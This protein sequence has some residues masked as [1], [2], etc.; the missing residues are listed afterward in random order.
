MKAIFL[1]TIISIVIAS[2]FAFARQPFIGTIQMQ[3]IPLDVPN[4]DIKFYRFLDKNG[5]PNHGKPDLLP[6][7]LF[8]NTHE[9]EAMVA[10]KMALGHDVYAGNFRGH[11]DGKEK[12]TVINYQEGDYSFLKMAEE[13]FPAMLKKVREISGQKVTIIGHSMGGMVPRA[14]IALGTVDQNDIE[15]MVLIGSPP[16]FR[17][18]NSF[19]PSVIEEPLMKMILAGSGKDPFSIMDIFELERRLDMVNVANPVYWIAKFGIGTSF[20]IMHEAVSF[21][22]HDSRWAHRAR[23]KQVPK[24]ILRSFVEYQKHYP[25][26]D[27][28]LTVPTL[29]IM[30][31]S[32]A[33]VRANDIRDH[34]P[35]Q[36]QE[37]GYWMITL[38]GV[39]HISLVAP[40]VIKAYKGPL[41]KFMDDPHSIG[42]ANETHIISSCRS[43]L[44]A[45]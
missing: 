24:D 4:A 9:F 1:A 2:P 31:E 23:T 18:K 19:L 20:D 5:E 13:D 42:P 40:D 11:G 45:I 25:F 29:Y 28:K 17:S 26:E 37:A 32:D 30:G 41:Q 15:S 12:S 38:R 35:V 7:G 6:H 10:E 36:S 8:S 33:I 14:S 39:G 44:N 16:H 43:L 21:W 34:A 22:I 27:V 3:Q